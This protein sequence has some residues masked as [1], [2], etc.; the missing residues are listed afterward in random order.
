MN[1]P[2][3]PLTLELREDE[4]ARASDIASAHARVRLCLKTLQKD[5]CYCVYPHDN[6]VLLD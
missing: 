5:G 3:F 4:V 1:I 6:P 2:D